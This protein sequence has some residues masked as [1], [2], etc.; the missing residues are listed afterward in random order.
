MNIDD[1]LKLLK[2]SSFFVNGIEIKPLT[3]GEIV[4]LGYL[5]Y[6]RY[7]KYFVENIEDYFKD[8]PDELKEII[9]FDVFIRSDSDI[10]NEF[11]NAIKF[12]FK[13]D[14]IKILGGDIQSTIFPEN[15]N[16]LINRDNWL[17][18]CKVVN[19]QNC[20]NK[21]LDDDYNP[22]SSKAREIAEKLRKAREKINKI[23]S[24]NN[25]QLDFSDLISCL[26]TNGNNLNLLNIFNLTMYQFNDQFKRMQMFEEY[27]IN[28]RSLLA[29]ADKDKIDLKHWISKIKV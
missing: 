11:T 13:E 17:Q 16:K 18:Y 10:L 21:T 7:L 20:V 22:K 25:E 8:I 4:D 23:K 9:P 24:K 19:I 27:D 14:K 2:G 15:K 3:I 1:E 28:I 5:Q 12:F 6:H 29:G 26:A